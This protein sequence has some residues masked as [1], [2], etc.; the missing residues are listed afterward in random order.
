MVCAA[1]QMNLLAHVLPLMIGYCVPEDDKHW[2]LFMQMMEIVDLLLPP[3]TS[4]DH[5]AYVATLVDKHHQEFRR[6]Y[7]DKSIIPKMHFACH[8]G[9][10]MTQ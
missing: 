9:R 8:M 4:D 10:L 6:L 5:T 3:N 1:S 7:P 2:L